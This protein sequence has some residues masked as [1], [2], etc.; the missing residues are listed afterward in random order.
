MSSYRF[1]PPPEVLITSSFTQN[2]KV[3][4]L[5]R[6]KTVKTPKGNGLVRQKFIFLSCQQ[7]RADRPTLLRKPWWNPVSQPRLLSRAIQ[8]SGYQLHGTI[9]L[10]IK[11]IENAV[12]QSRQPHLSAEQSHVASGFRIGQ[13]RGREFYWTLLLHG[14][15]RDL[16]KSQPY[17]GSSWREGDAGT[18]PKV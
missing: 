13:G 14:A 17:L 16:A 9:E 11:Q 7:S 15:P 6:A 18:S 5:V 3:I 4:E 1:V 2:S 8:Y 12:P 10:R